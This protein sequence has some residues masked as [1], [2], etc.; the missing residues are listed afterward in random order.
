[1]TM[2]SAP[3]R[4]QLEPGFRLDRYELLCVLAQGGMANVWLARLRG[5]HGFEKLVAIKT[6][7]PHHAAD[8]HFQQMFLD[9][10]RIASG[11]EH[12]N[13]VQILDL[14]EQHEHLYLVMELVEGDPMQRLHRILE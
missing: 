3:L 2:G 10:A 11:I 4:M 5:K 6:I 8:K 1:M 9:E 14:G 13:V 7:L 12:P